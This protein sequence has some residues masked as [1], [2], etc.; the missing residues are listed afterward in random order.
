MMPIEVFNGWGETKS[1]RVV[2]RKGREV[3]GGC[4]ADLISVKVGMANKGKKK[5]I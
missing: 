3:D 5:D 2:G 1:E 4:V